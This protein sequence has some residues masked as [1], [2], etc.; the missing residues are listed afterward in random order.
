L[1]G[2]RER[3]T[4]NT[5]P[6]RKIAPLTASWGREIGAGEFKASSEKDGFDPIMPDR[7][8]EVQCGCRQPQHASN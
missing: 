3:R 2:E 8:R 5:L 4:S 6:S 7:R 1:P